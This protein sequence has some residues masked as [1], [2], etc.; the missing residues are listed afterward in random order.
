VLDA[1][2]SDGGVT[3]HGPVVAAGSGSAPPRFWARPPVPNPASTAVTWEFGL[4]AP[5]PVQLLVCDTAGRIVA[6]VVANTLPA[7]AHM[8]RWDGRLPAGEFLPSGIYVYR[9]EAAGAVQTGKLVWV[10]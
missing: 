3:R 1:L 4:P 5:T 6:R 8:V 2:H 7:G 10:R 9:L